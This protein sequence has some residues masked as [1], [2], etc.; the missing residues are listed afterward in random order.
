MRPSR[1]R[2]GRLP[3]TLPRREIEER[4]DT[5]IRRTGDEGANRLRDEIRAVAPQLGLQGAAEDLD[6][7][8][9][10]LLGT[11]EESLSAPAARARSRGRPFDVDRMDLFRALH[12]ALRNEPPTSRPALAR[13]PEGRT[14]LAFFDAYFSNFIEG[15]EFEVGEASNIVFEGIIPSDRSAD[16]HDVLGTWNVVSD[17]GGMS[18]PAGNARTFSDLLRERHAQIMRGRPEMRPGQFKAVGNRA[19]STTFVAP[20][21]VEGTLERGFEFVRSLGTPLQRAIFTKFLVAEVHPFADGNGRVARVMMNA[22]LIASDEERIVI[23]TAFRNNYL[24]ALRALSRNSHPVPLIRVLDFAQR[25]TRAIDW[26]DLAPTGRQLEA[27]HAFLE[28]DEVEE[29][30]RQLLFPVPAALAGRQ[31]PENDIEPGM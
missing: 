14:T 17:E 11:R 5:L 29:T 6:R 28:P 15:T 4:L 24:S 18:R 7:L 10:A 30:G 20:D 9:G 19:G 23:P 22:E 13:L 25:W 31:E 2:G 12:T 27:C 8:I 21:L 16:A 3:R 26:G 1:A